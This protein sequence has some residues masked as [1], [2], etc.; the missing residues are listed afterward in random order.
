[1]LQS[2]FCKWR[3]VISHEAEWPAREEGTR[4]VAKAGLVHFHLK[5]E[6]NEIL[7]F[8]TGPQSEV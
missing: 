7:L 4:Q 5:N 2:P 3:L 1:M 6:I 8:R